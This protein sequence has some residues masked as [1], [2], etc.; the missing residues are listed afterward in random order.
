MIL[1]LFSASF[2][3]A[4]T[5]SWA[6]QNGALGI[7]GSLEPSF[8]I[9]DGNEN[10]YTV[11][12]FS[13]TIDFDPGPA[14]FNLSTIPMI[15]DAY[16]QKLNSNGLFQW[17]ISLAGNGTTR[18]LGAKADAAG[19]VYVC[20]NFDSPVDF[21]PG[22]ATNTISPQGVQDAFILKLNSSGI[23]QWVHTFGNLNAGGASGQSVQVDNNGDIVLTGYFADIVDFDPGP[24]NFSLAATSGADQ[25]ILKLNNAGNFVW[26]KAYNGSLVDYINPHSVTIDGANN[27]LT[28]GSFSGTFDFDPGASNFSLTSIQSDDIYITKLNS[29]GDLLWAKRIGNIGYESVKGLV[30]DNQNNYYVSGNFYDTLDMNPGP[31]INNLITSNDGGLFILKLDIN[32]N[33]IWAKKMDGSGY[34]IS[35]HISINTQGHLYLTG[36]FDA[37][38]DFDPGMSVQNLTSIGDYDIFV[39]K[40]DSAGNYLF[41]KSLGQGTADGGFKVNVGN[42]GAIYVMG[43]FSGTVDFNPAPAVN[44]LTATSATYNQFIFKWNVCN[45]SISATSAYHCNTYTFN[46]QTY[47]ASGSYTQL[48]QSASGCDSL[49]TLNLTIGSTNTTINHTQCNGSPYTLNGQTYTTAGTYTQFYSNVAGCDSNYILNL[50]FGTPSS[51]SYSDSGCDVYFF[52]NQILFNSGTYTEVFP[53]ASGCDST[54]TLNLTINNS[55][56]NYS[57]ISS[58]GPYF[59]NGITHTSAGYYAYFFVGA[60][61]CDSVVEFDLEI[62]QNTS[63]TQNINACGSYT[64]NGQTYTTSGTYMD[65]L[66]NSVGCD[67][68]VTLNLTLTTPNINVTQSGATLTSGATSPSTYQWIDCATNMPII[69]ATNQSYTATSNGSYAVIVT[70][71]NCS[72]TSACRPVTGIGINESEISN[73]LTIYPNPAKDKIYVDVQKVSGAKKVE[74]KNLAGQ[75][76]YVAQFESTPRI[77]ISLMNWA[78]GMYF[79]M[80]ESENKE[81]VSKFVKE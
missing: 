58:C 81:W 73:S 25:F 6:T 12:T 10:H 31:S 59:F 41:A 30:A 36:Y 7:N 62:K 38:T 70:L 39:S 8:S 9:L 76:I 2:M 1:I 56:Y 14:T 28:I 65:T 26:A 44:T 29:G 5:F 60:N 47:T 61:G 74:I 53:N 17:A 33:Y 11:G 78:K 64:F 24:A 49:V 50:N 80:I 35:E 52:G 43:L 4:Q 71:N 22:A 57:F 55:T 67:S 75:V 72:D 3:Q 32:G 20:G 15:T 27:I 79:L 13:E 68:V 23:F 69:G 54:V 16:I 40:L 21:N 66:M 42:S 48:F 37:V 18:I 77:E 34:T 45:P 51:S 46:G 63:S 19:N